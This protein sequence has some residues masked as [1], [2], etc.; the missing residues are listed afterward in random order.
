MR[1]RLA[2]VLLLLA[3]STTAKEL[4]A[5]A[6][7]T[8]Q[9][10]RANRDELEK[11]RQERDELQRRLNELQGEARDIT[12]EVTNLRR[13]ADATA[14]LVKSL[15]GQLS[16]ITVEVDSTNARLA[17]A[18]SDVARKKT[19]L[20][21]RVVDI[22]KR[23]PLYTVEALLSA[24]SFGEL[25]GRYKYLH[26]LALWDR[27]LVSR[28]EALYRQVAQQR[29]LLVRLR[30][31]FERNR[32][33]KAREEARLRTLERYQ[34]RTLANVQRTQQDVQRRL[35]NIARD[36]QR[37]GQLIASL[38][39]ARRRAAADD[40]ADAAASTSS[41]KAAD[42]GKLDW[43]VGGDILYR[44]GRLVS[45]D[46]TAVR[47]NGIGIGAQAGAPVRAVAAGEVMLSELLGTYGLTI[48]IQHGGGDYSV[49]GS[50]SA[51]N[52]R[53]GM[54]VAKGQ[55]I[56]A[57]GRADPDMDPHLHFEF[58]PKGRAVDPLTWL[59]AP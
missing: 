8:E 36:E 39:E 27:S 3:C 2:C 48:I 38:E 46:N 17:R 20:Q 31:E 50:L 47:W 11:I 55:I 57:V 29:Q 10:L 23:G 22:Y 28:V 6:Q 1:R 32:E 13:Q 43:P 40:P 52:V 5:Q 30:D 19:A 15:D 45:Q 54:Q 49:Y 12:E 18:E 56:G 16:T 21:R 34:T 42:A 25:V 4:T 7:S 9:R 26:E 33:E 37:L 14:R 35:T 53:K 59:R 58:R 24:R 51:A 41:I 44:F